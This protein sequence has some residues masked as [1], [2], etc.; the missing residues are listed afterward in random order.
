MQKFQLLVFCL[1]F[2]DVFLGYAMPPAVVWGRWLCKC[3]KY[4][5]AITHTHGA[6]HINTCKPCLSMCAW[7]LRK[8]SSGA[9]HTNIIH[10]TQNC[11]CLLCLLCASHWGAAQPSCGASTCLAHKQHRPTHACGACWCVQVTGALRNLAVA[12]THVPYTSSPHK[13][14][15]CMQ[16]MM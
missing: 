4:C 11:K 15:S 5:S 12:A 13:F 7:A 14:L 3:A 9:I 8:P 1:F 6:K 16:N 2:L 10:T